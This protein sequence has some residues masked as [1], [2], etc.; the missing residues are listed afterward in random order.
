[1]TG[2]PATLGRA[3]CLFCSKMTLR[4]HGVW[5]MQCWWCGTIFPLGWLLTSLLAR[6]QRKVTLPDGVL[7]GDRSNQA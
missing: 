3:R 2:P 7:R 5:S 1:M 6:S 4:S